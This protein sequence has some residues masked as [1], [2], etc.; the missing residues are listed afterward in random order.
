M[1]VLIHLLLYIISM[2]ITADRS[3]CFPSSSWND[4][5]V[6]SAC[7]Q[8]EHSVFC[9]DFHY[10]Q[11]SAGSYMTYRLYCACIYGDTSCTL[12]TIPRALP[13]FS[14]NY[15]VYRVSKIVVFMQ[16]SNLHCTLFT[17]SI[18]TTGSIFLLLSCH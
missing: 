18:I 4:V 5:G 8:P 2:Q 13:L 10:T 17:L 12:L 3:C 1:H 6:W 7:C 9:L 14:A 15:R 16:S 11:F